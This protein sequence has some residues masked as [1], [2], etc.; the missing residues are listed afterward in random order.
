MSCS[1]KNVN[2]TG[3]IKNFKSGNDTMADE[4]P[5]A[6]EAWLQNTYNARQLNNGQAVPDRRSSL[7]SILS[8]GS[9]RKGIVI[10]I[11]AFVLLA[12]I[13]AI[14]A[15]LVMLTMLGVQRVHISSLENQLEALRAEKDLYKNE[16]TSVSLQLTTCEKAMQGTQHQLE[17][18]AAQCDLEKGNLSAK[19]AAEV[20]K[21]EHEKELAQEKL[22]TCEG[23]KEELSQ[24]LQSQTRNAEAEKRA[25]G[26][27]VDQCEQ[28]K[29]EMAQRRDEEIQQ[30]AA[31]RLAAA[32]A[33]KSSAVNDGGSSSW[34]SS[35]R[36]NGAERSGSP[37]AVLFLFT[38]L[39]PLLFKAVRVV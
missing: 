8:V 24:R 14:G 9:K 22:N 7:K 18:N 1:A 21:G 11:M 6:S 31:E 33:A 37:K 5:A 30:R 17:I 12:G 10:G 23:S 3:F 35:S 20:R 4:D 19:L 39:L 2:D 32:D 13:V 34:W 25:L 15:S 29:R 38:M 26:D 28:Q 16:T 36:S 27:K